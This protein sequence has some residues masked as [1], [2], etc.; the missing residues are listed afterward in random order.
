MKKIRTER[1]RAALEIPD[2]PSKE[3]WERAYTRKYATRAHRFYSRFHERIFS[4]EEL[5]M[6]TAKAFRA[7]SNPRLRMW[8]REIFQHFELPYV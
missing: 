3:E 2:M 6:N 1:G 5:W 8:G 4:C 7:V